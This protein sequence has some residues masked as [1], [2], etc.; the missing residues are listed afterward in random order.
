MFDARTGATRR[1][2]NFSLQCLTREGSSWRVLETWG[3]VLAV[4]TALFVFWY[5]FPRLLD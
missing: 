3:R 2:D 5:V 4:E 1:K